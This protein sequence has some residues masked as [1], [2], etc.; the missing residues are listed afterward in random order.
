MTKGADRCHVYDLTLPL[1]NAIRYRRTLPT[2]VYSSR[3]TPDKEQYVSELAVSP[4]SV[5]HIDLPYGDRPAESF[6]FRLAPAE[7][8]E[9]VPYQRPRTMPALV[10]DL[11]FLQREIEKRLGTRSAAQCRVPSGTLWLADDGSLKPLVDLIGALRI[12]A[13]HLQ[14]WIPND[15]SLAGAAIIFRTGWQ[16]FAPPDYDLS[17]PLWLCW[18]PHHISPYLD[19]SAINL[20]LER[21]I[22]LVGSDTHSL[23]SPLREFGAAHAG[24]ELPPQMLFAASLADPARFPALCPWLEGPDNEARYRPTHCF[25]HARRKLLV[26]HLLIPGRI[27]WRWKAGK[28]R[29]VRD[30]MGVMG[31]LAVMPLP[32]KAAR[33]SLLASV[34][35]MPEH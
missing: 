3:L 8:Q 26:E 25:M 21:G 28:G 30:A 9:I 34:L 23:D 1:G 5:T 12:T 24:G 13:Q 11:A 16:R 15:F 19:A 14:T 35:F 18:H 29:V 22:E 32:D 27:F 17:H 10:I 7:M 33:E 20:L 4:H 6:P 2:T 31:N